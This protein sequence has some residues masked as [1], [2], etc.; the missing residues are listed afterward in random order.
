MQLFC[1]AN[2]RYGVTP[3]LSLIC[4]SVAFSV[5]LTCTPPKRT[6]HF[7]EG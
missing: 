2:F 6:G 3:R 7:A 1:R 4:A 5:S